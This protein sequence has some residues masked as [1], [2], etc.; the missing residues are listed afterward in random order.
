M[1]PTKQNS[2]LLGVEQV[3][4]DKTG[5]LVKP[6]EALEKIGVLE[7]APPVF[8]TVAVAVGFLVTV[9][10]KVSVALKIFSTYYFKSKV[11]EVAEMRETTARVYNQ[12]QVAKID[13]R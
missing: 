6:I 8:V 3:P 11:F 7:V 10:S 4:V 5:F 13:L 2:G 9:V 1:E 12:N